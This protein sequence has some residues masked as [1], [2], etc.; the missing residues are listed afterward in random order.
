MKT[1]SR[2]VLMLLLVSLLLSGIAM[3]DEEKRKLDGNNP[4]PAGDGDFQN[5][6]GLWCAD[7]GRTGTRYVIRVKPVGANSYTATPRQ[8][9]INYLDNGSGRVMT[10]GA[11]MLDDIVTVRTGTTI[12][13]DTTFK[14]PVQWFNNSETLSAG[15][16]ENDIKLLATVVKERATAANDTTWINHMD[17]IIKMCDGISQGGFAFDVRCEILFYVRT[18]RAKSSSDSNT[19]RTTTINGQGATPTYTFRYYNDYNYHWMTYLELLAMRKN[20]AKNNLV[21]NNNL[22]Q[23]PTWFEYV[24]TALYEQDEEYIFVDGVYSCSCDLLRIDK[25][26]NIRLNDEPHWST[27]DSSNGKYLAHYLYICYD[28]SNTNNNLEAPL[29]CSIPCKLGSSNQ[30]VYVTTNKKY[31]SSLVTKYNNA[32]GESFSGS[33]KVH[34]QCH[35]NT[36]SPYYLHKN[37]AG[38]HQTFDSKAGAE[39]YV[40]DDYTR[41]AIYE[42][43]D[44]VFKSEDI[45]LKDPAKVITHHYK[46]GTTEKLANDVTNSSLFIGDPYTTSSKKITGYVLDSNAGDPKSGTVNKAKIEVIYYYVPERYQYEVYH[47]VKGTNEVLSMESGAADFGSVIKAVDKKQT[48]PGY[49]YNSYDKASI[50]IQ[51]DDSK[52]VLNLYYVKDSTPTPS[53]TPTPTPSKTPTPTPSKTPTPTPSKTPTP[54]PTKIPTPT[55]PPTF[56]PTIAPTPTPTITPTPT[57]GT[58]KVIVHHYIKGTTTPVANDVTINKKIGDPYETTKASPEAYVFD[59]VAGDPTKGV[60]SKSKIEVIYYYVPQWYKYTVHYLEKETEKVLHDPKTTTA[61]FETKINA[62]DEVITI[63]KYSYDSSSVDAI[64]IS[65]DENKNVIKLF[66]VLIPEDRAQVITHHYLKG[67]TTK[68]FDDIIKKTSMGANYTTSK[69]TT[70]KEYTYDSTAGDPVSG[71]VTKTT[72]EVIYYYVP[73]NFEY[74]VNY[75]E[76]DT[77]KKLDTSKKAE[78][79]FEAT[80]YSK[81]EVI[82]I[83]EYKYDSADVESIKISATEKNVINLYY[84]KSEIKQGRVIAKYID[85]TTNKDLTDPIPQVGDVG[86]EY[87]TQEKKFPKYTLVERPTNAKGTFTEK[88]ITVIYYYEPVP[89][90]ELQIDDDGHHEWYLRGYED[91][92][93][94]M[95]GNVTREEV[96]TIFYRLTVTT[97]NDLRQNLKVTTKPYLDTELDRWSIRAIAYMKQL[98]IMGG[99]EDGTFLPSK[100]ITRAEFAAVIVNYIKNPNKNTTMFKDIP[101]D[102]WATEAISIATNEGWIQGYDDGSYKPEQNISRVEAVTIIN[103]MLKRALDPAQAPSIRIP[104]VDLDTTHWGYANVLEAITRHDYT[105]ND[106]GYEHWDSYEYPFHEDM[107]QDA[108]NDI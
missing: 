86:T 4:I 42:G 29:R 46:K 87:T 18:P 21:E 28:T 90:F 104:V 37:F 88:D 63:D 2:I 24:C 3:A 102:H 41:P 98:G 70:L 77:N 23:K 101:K 9:F 72:T 74:I 17:S 75:L 10:V 60:V 8:Y 14:H 52:N 43:W 40:I 12:F 38:I 15:L 13:T 6:D 81:D 16:S 48:F 33:S 30:T 97:N 79:P 99:Y 56:T 76:K 7:T 61:P 20:N 45:E 36:T 85:K 66:Y 31:D 108:Y 1:L 55:P 91:Y 80:I 82:P 107:S 49:T 11:D 68:V 78:A 92:T 65:I 53:K 54:T 106:N 32:T 96:A 69:L 51:V 27:N 22:L 39:Q 93:F 84:I 50:T 100:P 71:V 64:T 94:R 34:Y 57:P 25:N 103:R 105:K 73:K 26:A 19:V 5:F 95:T 89:E 58:A 35:F 47:K 67:T 59:S 83:N 44:Y 62:K